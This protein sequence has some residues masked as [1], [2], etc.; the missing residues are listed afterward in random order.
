MVEHVLTHCPQPELHD[1]LLSCGYKLA[2][3]A[4][5]SE[6][7][8]TYLHDDN[9]TRTYIKTLEQF[10]RPSGWRISADKLR[11]FVHSKT[12]QEIE[13]EPGGSDVTGHLLHYLKPLA[14]KGRS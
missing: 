9:I 5:Q 3:D 4:W 6:G 11:A 8:F 13:L 2:D 12:L 7:R 10:L 14:E 1:R